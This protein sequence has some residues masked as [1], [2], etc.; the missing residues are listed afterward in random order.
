MAKKTILVLFG[1]CSPE[2]EVSLQ[3]AYGVLIHM[4]QKKYHPLP[5]GITKEGRW[6]YYPGLWNKIAEDS[7]QTEE[8]VVP[9]TLNLDRG[10]C[11][12]LLLDGSEETL[13]FDGAF[14]M[15]H[16]QNGE[17]GTLQ[18]LLEL[19]GAPIIGC[20]TL[21]S[22]LCMDKDRAHKLAALA[23]VDVPSSAVVERKMG[24]ECIT[25]Q[26]ERIGYPV[27]VKPLRAGSSFGVSR[28]EN[29]SQ[30]D[31]AMQ[32]AFAFDS[33]VILEEAIPG[34]EVGCA[35]MGREELTVGLVD[36]I[37]LTGGVFDFE[38]KYTLKTSTIYCPA[39]ISP[40]K[41]EQIQ[42]V[43][44]RV[45]R[46]LGCQVF[47]RV[48][49]FLTPEGRIVFNEVNTIPGFTAHSRYPN[50]MKGIGMDFTALISHL[51]ELGVGK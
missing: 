14:P 21:A 26:A 42:Q 5:V 36:E 34:F 6:L 33:Q 50:M 8:G 32:Q 20:G 44:K 43:A 51:I 10:T 4:D 13:D 25:R 46:A 48:D 29:G 41:A 18:G 7:W 39:R 22:A 17:D 19:A 1:G 30:L 45:Y 15:L 24:R 27:F 2:Y 49:L 23:G 38:E 35:V 31:A 12:L 9:C 16:G 37:Q 47:A 11:Q 3:S 40:K 28:V